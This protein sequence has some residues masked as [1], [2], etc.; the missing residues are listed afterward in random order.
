[1]FYVY[2]ALAMLL[3]GGVQGVT[4]FGSA[5]VA[6]PLL[7]FFVPHEQ[8]PPTIAVLMLANNLLM[9]AE[10]RSHVR[11]RLAWPLAFAGI[12]GLPPGAF[13]LTHLDSPAFKLAVGLIVL[14]LAL[15]LLIG[16]RLKL[17]DHWGV[18]AVAGFLSGLMGGATSLSGPPVILLLANRQEAKQVFRANLVLVFAILNVAGIGVFAA[19]GLMTPQVWLNALGFMPGVLL[20]TLCGMLLARRLGEDVFRRIVLVLLAILALAVIV[21]SLQG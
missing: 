15:P 5:L 2:G 12:V 16:W 4:G 11:P 9:L 7:V 3:A 18:Q 1:M 19:L 6:V 13:L 8:I 10:I 20:G 21:G 17:P 14:A